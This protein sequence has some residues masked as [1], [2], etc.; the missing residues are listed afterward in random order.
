ML[1]VLKSYWSVPIDSP[2]RTALQWLRVG[3]EEMEYIPA[4]SLESIFSKSNL[5]D[6]TAVREKSHLLEFLQVN[7]IQGVPFYRTLSLGM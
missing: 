3:L 6:L 1:K 2:G 4:Q 7:S 5:S